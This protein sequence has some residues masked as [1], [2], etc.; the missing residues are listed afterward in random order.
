M[1]EGPAE[2]GLES[3]GSGP[4]ATTLSLAAGLTALGSSPIPP[5]AVPPPPPTPARHLRPAPP[6]QRVK[7]PVSRLPGPAHPVLAKKTKQSLA[8]GN[9]DAA[10]RLGSRRRMRRRRRKAGFPAGGRRGAG[11]EG[12]T[13]TA[14]GPCWPQPLQLLDCSVCIR[15][16][17]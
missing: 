9:P 17:D 7:S 15:I 2:T 6:L 3:G 16:S 4:E 1:T 13:P 10:G 5:E 12:A 14:H 11:P 8:T